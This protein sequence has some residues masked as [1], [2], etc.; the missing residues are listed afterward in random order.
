MTV[1]KWKRIGDAKL[2]ACCV[3]ESCT[4]LGSA[5]RLSNFSPVL[6]LYMTMLAW[7]LIFMIQPH[8]EERFMFPVYPS[9]ALCAAL[10]LNAVERLLNYV[11]ANRSVSCLTVH[12]VANKNEYFIMSSGDGW[13]F[14]K[15][16]CRTL[17]PSHMHVAHCCILGRH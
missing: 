14:G 13:C 12:F 15:Y 17:N 6:Y 11:Q 4:Y 16:L 3:I 5:S 9:I 10:T 7:M 1:C 2:K 8:K